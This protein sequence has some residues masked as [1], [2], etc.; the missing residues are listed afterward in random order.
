MN[1]TTTYFESTQLMNNIGDFLDLIGN[2]GYN[3]ASG[4]LIHSAH[5][6]QLFFDLKSGIAG[7]YL[8]KLSN[9]AMRAAI[10]LDDSHLE[11]RRFRE[12][13]SEA[14][15]SGSIAYFKEIESARNWLNR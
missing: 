3:R 7:E 1:N 10:I 12:M 11:H 9:Y 8:Q 15:R 4:V 5:L 14:N 13:V 6:P 2:A